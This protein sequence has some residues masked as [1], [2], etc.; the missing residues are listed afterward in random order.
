MGMCGKCGK[1]CGLTMLVVGLLWLVTDLKMV[2]LP[3]MG[4]TWFGVFLLVTGAIMTFMKC[5]EC[6]TCCGK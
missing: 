4:A 1:M 3:I 2:S 6:E 5:P